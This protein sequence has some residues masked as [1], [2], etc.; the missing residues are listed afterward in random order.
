MNHP[1][2]VENFK[3]YAGKQ[4]IGPFH[5]F[6]CVI[7]PNG[8][9][10]S[11]LMDAISFVLGVRSAQLRSTQLKDLIYRPGVKAD[12]QE[13]EDGEG[14]GADGSQ[15]KTRSA[16]VTAVVRDKDNKEFRFQR[17]CV[18]IRHTDPAAAL[19]LELTVCFSRFRSVSASGTSEYK[20]NGKTTT[21][22]SYNSVLES[23][24][25]LVRAKNFLVFQGDVEAVAQQ[26]PRD[27]SKLIESISGSGDLAADY[28]RLKSVAERA[29][30]SLTAAF[31]KRR[32][33][34]TEIKHFKEQKAEAARFD[35][36]RAKRDQAVVHQLVWKLHHIQQG[37]EERQ[38]K[39]NGK[40]DTLRGLRAEQVRAVFLLCHILQRPTTEHTRLNTG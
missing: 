32:G 15:S 21:Y 24:N 19:A 39:I 11:N 37:I 18:L 2:E 33:F 3:S 8:S 36:L 23:L 9:G 7:G 20:L 13:Q 22:A 31:N 29:S 12:G 1:A 26:S 34:N 27:L 35:Q 4:I 28:D 10:K 14:S 6:T 25:I 16:S 40:N 38:A 30:E 17:T 5:D